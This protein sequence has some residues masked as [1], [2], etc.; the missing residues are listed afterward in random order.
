[1]KQGDFRKTEGNPKRGDRKGPPRQAIQSRHCN[2]LPMSDTGNE[3]VWPPSKTRAVA[4]IVDDVA[5][6]T[7]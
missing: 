6:N 4:A 3:A 7:M 2:Q 1:M 5:S